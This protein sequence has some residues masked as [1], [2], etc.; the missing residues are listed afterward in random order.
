M[1]F[2]IEFHGVR[3]DGHATQCVRCGIECFRVLSM[4]FNNRVKQPAAE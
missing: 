4:F 2:R 1:P 3:E